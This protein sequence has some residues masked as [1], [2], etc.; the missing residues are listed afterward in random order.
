MEA[1]EGPVVSA[2]PDD[3]EVDREDYS[4]ARDD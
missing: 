1:D 3:V 2:E 4:G